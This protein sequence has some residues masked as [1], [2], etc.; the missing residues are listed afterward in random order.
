MSRFILFSA[1]CLFFGIGSPV[2][3]QNR[4]INDSIPPSWYGAYHEKGN[5]DAALLTLHKST[6][7]CK[8]ESYYYREITKTADGY[9]IKARSQSDSMLLDI[10]MKEPYQLHVSGY[11]LGE[12]DLWET[13]KEHA[14]KPLNY[15][16]LPELIQH[17]W[18]LRA[19]ES[20]WYPFHI[21]EKGISAQSMTP[22]IPDEI[23]M[24]GDRY[25]I[26]VNTGQGKFYFFLQS[27][28]RHYLDIAMGTGEYRTYTSHFE[29]P[30][31]RPDNPD[32][33]PACIWSDWRL[34]DSTGKVMVTPGRE[35]W[36]V[37]GKTY[38]MAHFRQSGD[39][40]YVK[41][42]DQPNLIPVFITHLNDNYM[43]WHGVSSPPLLLKSS[44]ALPNG[45][46]KRYDQLPGRF[47][48]YWYATDGS[49]K[50]AL[51]LEDGS[52]QLLGKAVKDPLIYENLGTWHMEFGSKKNPAHLVMNPLNFEYLLV[53]LTGHTPMLMKRGRELPDRLA[54]SSGEIPESFTGNWFG[55]EKQ[56]DYVFTLSREFFIYQGEFFT[57]SD[58]TRG[59]CD[60][61]FIAGNGQHTHRVKMEEINGSYR[62]SIGE[63]RTVTV[64][65]ERKPGV[66]GHNGATEYPEFNYVKGGKF[67]LNGYV[68][69]HERFPAFSTILFY[70]SPAIKDKQQ[71]KTV[72]IGK[73]GRFRLEAEM[74]YACELAGHFGK[75]F[76]K[77]FAAPGHE[78][79]MVL[80]ASD[81]TERGLP[82][83]SLA[84]SGPWTDEIYLSTD[85]YRS[86]LSI[87][88]MEKHTDHIRDDDSTAYKAYRFEICKKD[89]SELDRFCSG[90]S[91]SPFFRKWAE[92][93]VSFSYFDDLMRFRWLKNSYSS[94]RSPYDYPVSTDWLEWKAYLPIDKNLILNTEVAM[95]FHEHHMY[96]YTRA[97]EDFYPKFPYLSLPK[98]DSG[99]ELS[100]TGYYQA[101]LKRVSKGYSPFM[102]D[103]LTAVF[104]ESAF[105]REKMEIMDPVVTAFLEESVTPCATDFLRDSYETFRKYGKA[106]AP[107]PKAAAVPA[108]D[109]SKMTLW[110]KLIYPHRGKVIYVDFWATWCGPCGSQFPY[111]K[112]LHKALE[113]KDVVFMYLCGGGSKKP[114]WGAMIE[115]YGLKGDHH[116]L[117]EKQWGEV[118]NKFKIAG[119]PHYV[120]VDPSGQVA[121][122]EADR[123]QGSNGYNQELYKE[124]LRLTGTGTK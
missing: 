6:A 44:A 63:T 80:N 118:T 90:V 9:R 61:E 81:Y 95:I 70:W 28:G 86:F 45:Y 10:S 122:I 46:Q 105:A 57:Y 50:M 108:A 1:C 29:L 43:Q 55:L 66:P 21:E 87:G 11:P 17:K 84:L 64:Q 91:Y 51:G 32:K 3:G 85:Y 7:H 110:E 82:A 25:R 99:K 104:Y 54:L 71:Q 67:I 59:A 13:W 92:T 38:E 97:M 106:G 31:T 120:L 68:L 96:N 83:K 58:I 69:N 114:A 62:C 35:K 16:D 75:G 37:D 65:R 111:S 12:A 73:D 33:L 88:P 20:G 53:N 123:P 52:M 2:H 36:S 34:T 26:L 100:K 116:L 27:P 8:G 24:S 77:F 19:N 117:D 121:D 78:N 42:L 5:V 40:V 49:G 93:R 89:L 39:T 74:D 72:T 115:Q 101:F 124:I 41:L 48:G 79:L 47:F 94:V 113:G 60:M 102:R 107:E 22:Y 4:V 56:N 109:T 30:V 112:D 14:G 98:D 103:V 23:L 15:K 18:Y 119:I 76:I